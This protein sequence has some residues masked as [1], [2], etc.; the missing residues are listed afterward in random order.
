MELTIHEY[1]FSGVFDKT[2]MNITLKRLNF[3]NGSAIR[4]MFFA[5]KASQWG[6]HAML[7]FAVR[8]EGHK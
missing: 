7:L 2:Y 5:L 8:P 1:I 6:M 3:S 4:A